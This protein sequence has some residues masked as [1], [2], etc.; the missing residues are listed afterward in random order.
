MKNATGSLAI[1]DRD[2]LLWG[3][4]NSATRLYVKL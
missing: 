2:W 1:M 3:T 4:K